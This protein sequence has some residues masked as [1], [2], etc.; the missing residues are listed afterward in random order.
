MKTNNQLKMDQSFRL[1]NFLQARKDNFKLR[2]YDGIATE[3][4]KELGFPITASN[5]KSVAKAAELK[6]VITRRSEKPKRN[7]SA[8][9]DVAAVLAKSIL[10]L[11]DVLGHELSEKE[12]LRL[13]HHRYTNQ[14]RSLFE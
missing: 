4:T 7:L 9:H 8:F 10:E 1:M 13:I 14:V 5:V 12:N 2:S 6:L 11:S 3:A